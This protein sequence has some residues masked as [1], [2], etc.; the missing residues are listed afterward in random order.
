MS[1]TIVNFYFYVDCSIAVRYFETKA[2]RRNEAV[3]RK[4]A[5]E[6]GRRAEA[7][8]RGTGPSTP[9]GLIIK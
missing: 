5:D 3:L 1:F 8:T 4:G 6:W 2:G 7:P 9:A